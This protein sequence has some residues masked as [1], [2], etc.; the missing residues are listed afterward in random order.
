MRRLIALL[1]ALFAVSVSNAHAQTTVKPKP[2]AVALAPADAQ[3]VASKKGKTYYK[4]GCKAAWKL[5]KEDL[6]YF[7]TEDEA[8]SAGYTHSKKGHC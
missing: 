5:T 1:V 8:K 6:V 3:F 2:P 4:V 7:K